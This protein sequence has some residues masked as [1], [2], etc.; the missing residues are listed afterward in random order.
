MSKHHISWENIQEW[1]ADIAHKIAAD[2][3]DIN[4]MRSSPFPAAA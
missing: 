1:S 2:C 3:P 4:H